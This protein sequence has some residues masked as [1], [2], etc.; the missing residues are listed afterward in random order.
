MAVY[1][2][3]DDFYESTYSLI[4]IHSYL[5][6]YRLA[7]FLNLHLKTSFKRLSYNLDFENNSSFSIYQWEDHYEE[8]TWHLVTNKSR[9]EKRIASEDGGLFEENTASVTTFLVPEYNKAD[10][11]L[12]ADYDDTH[13]NL[14][15]T[16]QGILRIPHITTAYSI[17]P[18]QLKSKNNLIF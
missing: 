17:D 11:F 15:K 3:L 8:T 6:D 13:K 5:E 16:L 14:E 1:K 12:K 18:N 10:F 9:T 2:L 4:A 7:Y